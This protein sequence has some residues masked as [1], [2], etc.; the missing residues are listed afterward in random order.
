MASVPPTATDTPTDAVADVL[1]AFGEVLVAQRRLRGRDARDPG[2][3]NYA[4][5]RLLSVVEDDAGSPAS[6]L[7][8]RAGIT[9]GSVTPMLDALE[10]RG[11][12]TRR[13]SI[14]DRRVVLTFITDAG[15]EV[16]DAKLG[17]AR[18]AFTHAL[19]GLSPAELA[20]APRVLRVIADVIESL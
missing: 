1:A 15:R 7:A 9:P 12:V 17:A 4:H 8:E 19:A 13:R 16:R 11:L 2:D 10:R 14:D 18:A 3:L 20:A 5:A 6:V